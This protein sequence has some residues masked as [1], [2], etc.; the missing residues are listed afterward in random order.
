M[1]NFIIIIFICLSCLQFWAKMV[2]FESCAFKSE[3]LRESISK[4]FEAVKTGDFAK[5]LS[6][7]LTSF[8]EV[9]R[10]ILECVNNEPELLEKPYK[11]V[12]ML[13]SCCNICHIFGRSKCVMDYTKRYC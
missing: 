10:D 8:S 13:M 1:K 11:N 5:I 12:L 4:V 3:K 7:G 2:K 6:I 9:K